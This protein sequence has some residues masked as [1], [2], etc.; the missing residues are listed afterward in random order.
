MGN[1]EECQSLLEQSLKSAENFSEIDSDYY[2][3]VSVTVTYNLARVHES[4][5]HFDRAE[6]LYKQISKEYP[7]YVDCYVRL[8]CMARAKGQIS[9]ASDWFREVIKFNTEDPDGWSL[10]A[11][12]FMDQ[13]AYGA[14]QKKFEKILTFEGSKEDHYAIVALGNIW[15]ETLHQK[16]PQERRVIHENRALA[17][18]KQVL[19]WEPK[20]I[21][22]ANGI[23]AVLANKG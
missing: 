21:W 3:G 20:N 1:I 16:L 9:E 18:F 15:L 22:A 2:P 10:M 11:N 14:A 19:R 5:S 12:L 6:C 13:T 17:C 4:L 23:G 8:G 7:K